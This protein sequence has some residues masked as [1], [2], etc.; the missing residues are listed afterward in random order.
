VFA[1][2]NPAAELCF[3]GEGPAQD[4]DAKASPSSAKPGS[5]SI[6]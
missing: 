5:C 1:R 2:G 6:A 3:V 4:E